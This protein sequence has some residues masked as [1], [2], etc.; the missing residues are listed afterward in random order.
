MV[1][2][3]VDQLMAL[4]GVR[5]ENVETIRRE[6]NVEIFAHGN[7]ITLSGEEEKVRQARAVLEMQ[8]YMTAKK[9]RAGPVKARGHDD[10]AAARSRACV[11]GGLNRGGAE[12]LAVRSRAES[13]DRIR[14]DRILLNMIS[15]VFRAQYVV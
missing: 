5:D 15:A 1:V 13:D 6:L 14:H 9:D 11:D 3:G 8:L 4:F 7:E 12:R 10:L 2:D